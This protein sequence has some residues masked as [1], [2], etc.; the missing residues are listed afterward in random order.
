MAGRPDSRERNVTEFSDYIVYV[1]ESGDHGL[2]TIDP[3]Y[4]A[5]LEKQKAPML[6]PRPIVDREPPVL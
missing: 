4:N 6:P 1:D 5:S 3:N 2:K